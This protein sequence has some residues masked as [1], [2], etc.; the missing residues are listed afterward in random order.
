MFVCDEASESRVTVASRLVTAVNIKTI[1]LW[2][3]TPYRLVCWVLA[4]GGIC[5]LYLQGSVGVATQSALLKMQAGYTCE[6]LILS[7]VPGS[8]TNYKEFWIG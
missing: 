5:C 3:V 4:F 6:T 1:F 7:R 2:D 8:V